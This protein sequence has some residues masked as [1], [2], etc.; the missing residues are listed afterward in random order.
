MPRRAPGAH[1][2]ASAACATFIA[3]L[4]VRQIDGG[5]SLWSAAW[6]PEQLLRDQA[7]QHLTRTAIDRARHRAPEVILESSSGDSIG[8]G[9]VGQG[10]RAD[11]VHDLLGPMDVGF[12]A[13]ECGMRTRLGAE[14]LEEPDPGA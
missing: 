12:G 13:E 9:P 10:C 7:A 6:Q 11:H 1:S 4:G 5:L 2:R 14:L 8:V 3:S